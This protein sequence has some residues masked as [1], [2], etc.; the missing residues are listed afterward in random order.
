MSAKHSLEETFPILKTLGIAIQPHRWQEQICRYHEFLCQENQ[1]VNLTR[2]TSFNDYM[3]KHVIDSL[4][5]AV[6]LPTIISKPHEIADVGCGAGFPGV[7]LAISYPNLRLTEIDSVNKKFIFVQQLVKELNLENCIP[8]RGRAKE[9]ALTSEFKYKFDLVTAR[10]VTN[11]P[12]V[13]Q[14]CNL[15]LKKQSGILVLYKTPKKIEEEMD[16]VKSEAVKLQM[17]VTVSPKYDLP[18]DFGKRQF[19]VIGHNI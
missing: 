19:L 17:T 13:M 6:Y 16:D 9:L 11:A 15:F 12:T 1:K 3:I 8:Q 7:P 14:D 4:L 5:L 10:A 2:I 18:C